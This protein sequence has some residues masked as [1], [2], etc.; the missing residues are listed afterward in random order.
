MGS[1]L[2]DAHRGLGARPGMTVRVSI[3]LPTRNGMATLPALFS[4]LER[5]RTPYAFEIVAIDSNST[6]GTAEWLRGRVARLLTV[7]AGGFDHG[8]SRNAAIEAAVGEYVVLMVQDAVPAHDDW[9]QNLVAPLERDPVLAGTFARQTPRADASPLARHY[10]SIW[11]ANAT[12]PRTAEPLERREFDALSPAARLNRCVFDNVCS[13]IRRSV[14]HAHRFAATPIAED[15]EW[16]LT[17]LLAGH[18]LAYVPAAE[19]VH[20]HDRSARYELARTYLLHRRLF[21]LFGLRTI[22]SAAALSRS[23]A[24]TLRLHLRL[25]RNGRSVALAIAWPLGQY[26]GGLTAARGWPAVRLRGV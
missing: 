15:V 1:P 13:C 8:L 6:D 11:A 5:Q 2:C 4:A 17:V 14:W 21:E 18:R 3:V 19:V 22:P 24:S 20:S 10:L 26:L 23:I 7:A 9:L 25:Q 16:A 12:Q